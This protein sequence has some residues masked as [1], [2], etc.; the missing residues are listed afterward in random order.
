M[1]RAAAAAAHDLHHH[2]PHRIIDRRQRASGF[3]EA[4]VEVGVC[5]PA[6]R[7]T[8][9]RSVSSSPGK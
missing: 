7:A 6:F 9:D 4:A 5:M 8:K 3:N 1:A 2:N